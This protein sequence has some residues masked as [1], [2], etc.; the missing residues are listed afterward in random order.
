MWKKDTYKIFPSCSHH[1]VFIWFFRKISFDCLE[2]FIAQF[3]GGSRF[4][5]Q[6]ISSTD[7]GVKFKKKLCSKSEY[8][9][10]SKF[11]G[12]D[13]LRFPAGKSTVGDVWNILL[14]FLTLL[15]QVF[16]TGKGFCSFH[17]HNRVRDESEE[18][19]EV[20]SSSGEQEVVAVQEGKHQN[21]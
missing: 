9:R 1:V 12:S 17:N 21:Q 8:Y 18:E 7:R 3:R 11:G 13:D 4:T 5:H 16:I 6:S 14:P 19:E 2:F 15:N 10:L 20:G